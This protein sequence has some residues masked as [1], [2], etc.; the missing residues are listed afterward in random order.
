[1]K[2]IHAAVFTAAISC[3]AV[4]QAANVSF[5]GMFTQDDN[6]QLV[7]F[8]LGAAT[9]VT[10]RTWSYAGGIN[11]AGNVIAAGGFDPVLAL[12]SP[13]GA[14]LTQNDDGLG[15]DIDLSTFGSY[16]ALI[17]RMLQPGSY[18]VSLAQSSNFARGPNLSDGFSRAGEGNFTGG[19]AYEAACAGVT[20]F[21]DVSGIS[22]GNMRTGQWALDLLGVQTAA[23][24]GPTVIPV[25]AALPLLAA[26]LGMFGIFFGRRRRLG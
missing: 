10:I 23:L 5:T 6:V 9:D 8:S 26:G 1:M 12:F 15:V 22:P 13:T 18:T 4:A 2:R 7:S 24:L 21:C 14:L 11:A 20:Q 16:D 17:T 3:S 19:A 25:P